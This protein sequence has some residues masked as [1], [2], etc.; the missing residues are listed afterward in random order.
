MAK[1]V[2]VMVGCF[3]SLAAMTSLAQLDVAESAGLDVP[4]LE[5]FNRLDRDRD[6]GLEDREFAFGEI[7]TRYYDAGKRRE[8]GS[9]FEG[10]DLDGNEKIELLEL[11]QSQQNR[12]SRILSREASRSFIR[13]DLDNDG[14]IE[15]GEHEERGQ[16]DPEVF[17]SIDLNQSG[18]I[19]PLEWLLAV[20]ERDRFSL[21][22]GQVSDFV[23][24]DQ[25]DDGA[26]SK[27]E[28]ESGDPPEWLRGDFERIDLN[29]N[30]EVGPGEFAKA[31]AR[32]E[33]RGDLVDRF[34]EIDRNRDRVIS[35]RE[36]SRYSPRQKKGKFNSDRFRDHI[37]EKM[38]RDENGEVSLEEYS[39][40]HRYPGGPGKG[41]GKMKGKFKGSKE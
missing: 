12:N 17:V 38:D 13:A 36:F 24:L 11:A 41:K 18:R 35:H 32:P 26:I 22:P 31:S 20:K 10:M 21:D 5:E 37:F 28:F 9:V 6:G 25:N 40:F 2:P 14:L 8:L 29:G 30:R 33:P 15:S 23:A 19:G 3:Y 1:F 39:N 16:A 27:S 4:T 7:A 34:N